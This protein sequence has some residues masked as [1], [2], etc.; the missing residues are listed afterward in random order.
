MSVWGL[1]EKGDFAV[2]NNAFVILNDNRAIVQNVETRIKEQTFDCF[3]NLNAGINWV[4]LP[5]NQTEMNILQVAIKNITA[6]TNGVTDVTEIKLEYI[7]ASRTLKV[8][9]KYKTKFTDEN[10]SQILFN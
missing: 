10:I 7:N 2:T 1:D 8:L 6:G 9:I 3:V 4:N 5:K